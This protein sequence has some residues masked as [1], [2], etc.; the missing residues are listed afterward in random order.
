MF[1]HVWESQVQGVKPT[2][3]KTVVFK[4]DIVPNAAFVILYFFSLAK[5]YYYTTKI[6]IKKIKTNI[7]IITTTTT[8]DPKETYTGLDLLQV[9][10][11][12][13]LSLF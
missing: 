13:I 5:D 8:Q 11:W 9:S 1:G 3:P 2:S 12:D 10:V 6:I 7:I 4:T